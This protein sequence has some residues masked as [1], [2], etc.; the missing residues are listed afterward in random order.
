MHAWQRRPTTGQRELTE[1]AKSPHQDSEHHDEN[2]EAADCDNEGDLPTRETRLF[3]F[4]GTDAQQDKQHWAD[5]QRHERFFG[6]CTGRLSTPKRA[7]SKATSSFEPTLIIVISCLMLVEPGF[8][9]VQGYLV[10]RLFQACFIG[11]YI[12]FDACTR[13]HWLHSASW[14]KQK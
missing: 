5:K 6:A 14:Q 1:V 11:N 2:T 7:S 3:G 4:D 13:G 10:S 12:E 8:R 9:W